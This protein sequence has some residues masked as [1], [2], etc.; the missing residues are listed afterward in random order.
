MA[1]LR[2]DRGQQPVEQ[3]ATSWNYEPAPARRVFVRVG[4]SMNLTWW[5]ANLVGS[6]RLAVEVTYSDRVFFL[7]DEDGSGWHKVTHGGGPDLSSRSLPDDSVV[8]GPAS[9]A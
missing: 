8:I 5:C 3:P 6:T 1:P 9:D 7:D 2:P 4:H